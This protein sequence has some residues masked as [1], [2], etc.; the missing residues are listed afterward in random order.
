MS[1]QKKRVL[2]GIAITLSKPYRK[3]NVSQDTKHLS[4]GAVYNSLDGC[5]EKH[6]GVSVAKVQFSLIF[7]E[8]RTRLK[9]EVTINWPPYVI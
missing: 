5:S 9:V 6:K 8:L 1:R 4:L 2:K 3:P 7:C